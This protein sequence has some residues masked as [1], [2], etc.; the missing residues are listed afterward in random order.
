MHGSK[1]R[2]VLQWID[3]G[4]EFRHVCRLLLDPPEGTHDP[5]RLPEPLLQRQ[6]ADERPLRVFNLAQVPGAVGKHQPKHVFD[7]CAEGGAAGVGVLHRVLQGINELLDGDPLG[8]LPDGHVL[9]VAHMDGLVSWPAVQHEG[10][11]NV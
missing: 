7:G 3:S 9:K 8:T 4:L 6:Q 1:E 5:H 2:P 10:L 11:H